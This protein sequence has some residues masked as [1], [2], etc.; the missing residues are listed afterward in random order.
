MLPP[1]M[2][3]LSVEL[4]EMSILPV[5]VILPVTFTGVPPSETDAAE[6][7]A[8]STVPPC[9]PTL[10]VPPLAVRLP[11]VIFRLGGLTLLMS[12]L[13]LAFRAAVPLM[14]RP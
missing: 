11:P 14:L 2:A 13:R 6:I 1:L 3:P 10:N 7:S 4:E 12:I 8:T 9:D 5:A